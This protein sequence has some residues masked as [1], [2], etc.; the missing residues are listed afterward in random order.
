MF[1]SL[2]SHCLQNFFFQLNVEEYENRHVR[3]AW[4]GSVELYTSDKPKTRMK[5]TFIK[6][7]SHSK[8]SSKLLCYSHKIPWSWRPT[9]WVFH[10]LKFLLLINFFSAHSPAK[11]DDAEGDQCVA[12]SIILDQKR[13]SHKG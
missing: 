12:L 3:K 2:H 1:S 6:I 10:T 9:S 8:T 4:D 5:L 13:Y 11:T 7:L